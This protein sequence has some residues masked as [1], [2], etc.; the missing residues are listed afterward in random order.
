[1]VNLVA[2]AHRLPEAESGRPGQGFVRREIGGDWQQAEAFYAA[3]AAFHWIVDR[4]AE[5]LVAAA[6]PEDRPAA[7]HPSRQRLGDAALAQPGQ[8]TDGRL[9][10]RQHDEVRRS[11]EHTSE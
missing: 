11:E 1:M 4:F 2:R 8:I 3:G 9:R 10:A 5:H 6:D 7:G